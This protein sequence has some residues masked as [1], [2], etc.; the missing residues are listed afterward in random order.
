L[1]DSEAYYPILKIAADGNVMGKHVNGRMA[2]IIGRVF[3]VL[4]TVAAVA[5][6]PL[7]ILTHSGK[8]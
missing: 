8:P 5:A 2:T 6:I 4:I 1:I 7:M 3:L